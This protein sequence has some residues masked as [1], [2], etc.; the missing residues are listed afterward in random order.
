MLIQAIWWGAIFL[1]ALLLIRGLRAKLLSRFPVFY[2]YVLFVFCEDL[3]R[4]WIHR[5]RPDIYPQTYWITVFLGLMMGS[6]LVFEIYLIGLSAYPGTARMARNVLLFVFVV[7]FAK[8]LVNAS[9]GA[10]WWPAKTTLELE[11]NLRIVQ[12]FAVISLITLFLVYA[13]PFGRNLKGILFGYGFFIA[14]SVIQLTL[15]SYFGNKIQLLW[16]YA[17]PVSYLFVLGIW[18]RALWA[19]QP[20]PGTIP[21][22]Q[23][24]ND[25]KALIAATNRRFHEARA[26]LGR[27]VRP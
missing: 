2:S 1:E 18:V 5:W 17:Q 6:V 19:Y 24:E 4:F 22:A 27:V 11:R 3:L 12:A 16:S 13:I 14:V 21:A 7:I 20:T 26:S 23:L 25:Y 10:V 15:V 9:Y 8:A